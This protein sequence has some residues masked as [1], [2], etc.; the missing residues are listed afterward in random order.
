MVEHYVRDVG[1]AG[2]NPVTSIFMIQNQMHDSCIWFFIYIFIYFRQSKE[3]KTTYS[4]TLLRQTVFI[5]VKAFMLKRKGGSRMTEGEI[6]SLLYHDPERGEQAL[7]DTYYNYVYA[8]IYR[9]ICG[10][11]THEDAEECVIDVFLEVLKHFDSIRDGSLR[12]YIGTVAR[13]RA[14][15]LCRYVS[16]KS[17]S[18]ESIEEIGQVY[19]SEQDVE[20]EIEQSELTERLL[21]CIAALGEPDATILIQKFYYDRNAREIASVIGKNPVWVRNRCSRAIKRLRKAFADLHEGGDHHA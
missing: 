3:Q 1:A 11:G 17:R 8:I 12:A 19:A 18:T 10:I 20:D 5:Y 9:R 4:D 15:N 16:A 2:S 7:F 14:S 21:S 6:R 13:N